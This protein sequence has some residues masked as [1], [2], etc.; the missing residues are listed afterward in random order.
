MLSMARNNFTIIGV[1]SH[2][3][4]TQ[5]LCCIII[6]YCQK[7][8]FCSVYTVDG[9]KVMLQKGT[10]ARITKLAMSVKTYGWFQV[11]K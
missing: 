5:F 2:L 1:I 8:A 6:Q 11:L 10:W 4:L 9:S 7:H 3:R